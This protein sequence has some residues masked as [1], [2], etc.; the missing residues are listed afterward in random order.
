MSQEDLNARAELDSIYMSLD[1][2]KEEIKKRWNNAALKKQVTD[3]LKGDIPEVFLNAPRA[4]I[5]RQVLSPNFEMIGFEK[6]A[7]LIDLSPVCFGYLDDKLVTK[8]LDKYYLCKLFF[9]DGVGRKGGERISLRKILNFNDFNGESFREARTNFGM[10]FADFHQLLTRSSG[11]Q[12]DFFD[13]SDFLRK[14]GGVS[15]SYYKYFLS[16]F[17][18]HGVLFEN[19][20]LNGEYGKLTQ[21]VFLPNYLEVKKLFGVRPIIVRLVDANTEN[22]LHWRH[23]PMISSD[24]VDKII[25][26]R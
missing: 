2:A 21:D 7:R 24:I 1:E 11:V 20:L 3:F 15:E 26:N 18:C 9:E 5:G 25:Q 4:I 22:D 6:L 19:Y 14:H 12:V 23:Y 17:I 10:G 13:G 16:L 8:N